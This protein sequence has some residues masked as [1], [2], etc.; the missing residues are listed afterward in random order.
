VTVKLPS[1]SAVLPPGPYML[2]VDRSTTSGLVPSVSRPVMVLGADASCA[3][4]S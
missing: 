1:S 3:A 4:G 2:F